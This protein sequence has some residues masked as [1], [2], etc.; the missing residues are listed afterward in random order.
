MLWCH[1]LGA[2]FLVKFK[3]ELVGRSGNSDVIILCGLADWLLDGLA[4]FLTDSFIK[5]HLGNN[6]ARYQ[7]FKVCVYLDQ[8]NQYLSLA[9]ANLFSRKSFIV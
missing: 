5:K 2:D 8:H 6:E 9:E 4:V 1:W 7:R 3:V